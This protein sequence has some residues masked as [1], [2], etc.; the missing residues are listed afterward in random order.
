VQW[1]KDIALIV[2]FLTWQDV[3]FVYADSLNYFERFA[4]GGKKSLKGQKGAS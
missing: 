1:S 3:Y 4:P 2:T